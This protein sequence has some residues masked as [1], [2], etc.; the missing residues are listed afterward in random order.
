MS[1]KCHPFRVGDFRESN[2]ERNGTHLVWYPPP[3]RQILK[4][5]RL[6]R[7]LFVHD[8][9]ESSSSEYLVVLLTYHRDNSYDQFYVEHT[10]STS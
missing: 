2:N 4:I 3:V 6:M 7:C 1:H 5:R 8:A 10:F 9:T